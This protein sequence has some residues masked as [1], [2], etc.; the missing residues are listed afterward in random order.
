[1][2][3]EKAN[4]ISES[5]TLKITA[6]TMAMKA[7]GIDIIDLSVGEP[8]FPTP[9]NVKKEGIKAIEENF[10]KYTQNEGIPA[11]IEAIIKRLKEDHNLAYTKDEIIVSSGAKSSLYH[12]IQTL[13]NSGNEVIVPAP[14]WVTYPHAVSLAD[15]KAVIIPTKEEN[16]FLLTAD[17][18]KSAI[19][20]ATK[21]LILNNPSNPTGAAY[22]KHELEALADIVLDEDIYVIADEIYE[23]LVYDDFRFTSFAALGEEIKKKTIII[24]GVS[25]AYSMTGWRIGY[26][27][28]PADIISGMAKIQSHSTS[29]PCSISQ[30]ASL[31]ALRG[32]QYE[33]SRM[34]SEFQRRR[35]YALMRLQ[36]VPH[37]SCCKPQGAF[38]LFPN[39]S[40]YY[41]KEFNNTQIRNSYGLA[42]YF[43]KEAKVAIVPGDSFG[44]DDY[45]RISFATSMENLEKGMD[46]IIE[47]LARLKTAKKVKRIAL[48]NTITVVKKS[49]PMDSSISV[50]MRDAFVAEME[51]H[52]SYDNYFE[53]NANINGVIVQLR[54]NVSHLNDFWV[55]NWYPAQ[56]EA[57][58]EPHG[59]IYAVDGITGRE[60][61]SFY[62]SET[63][64]GV[65]VNTDSYSPL[66]SLAFGLVMDVSERL[67]NV[68]AVRGMTA[69]ISGKGALLIGPKGTK[70][71]ELFFSLLQDERFRLHANDLAFVRFSGGAPLAFSAERKLYMA[72]NTADNYPRLAALFDNSK[73]ENVIIRKEDCQNSECLSLDDCRLDRGSPFCYKASKNAYALLD[74]YWIEGPKKHAKR[75]TLQWIFLLR[76]DT[77]SPPVVEVE[78]EDALRILESGENL[79]LQRTFSPSKAQPFYN[80]HLLLTSPERMELQRSF[81]LRLCESAKCYLFNSGVASVDNIKQI[82]MKEEAASQE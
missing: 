74:P 32:P 65:L 9:D 75:T 36:S 78:V 57:D 70:K 68:H 52:L 23:K 46:R 15:G 33:V 13:L 82:I 1:M 73:C 58:L 25:K 60:P 35:N 59:I 67:F 14:Y 56:L 29:H 16:G 81:F 62:N 37:I 45:I 48:N 42:Y 64:T 5:P 31:E 44:C 10:T 28:G 26:A 21:A 39:L 38:Y 11:L 49:V 69:D 41:G 4:K 3:S 40:S 54:T 71:T 51:S 61:R 20:P 34:V 27:A 17:Q 66:R 72:T 7:E 19:S 12:L 76:Y 50:N 30:K 63:K 18:L 47:A 55:E 80:P 79:G 6:K 43:L 8:D 77:T 24:N 53:W 22:K 2:V